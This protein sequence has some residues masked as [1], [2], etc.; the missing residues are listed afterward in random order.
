M[1]LG[2]ISPPAPG[3][4]AG[5]GGISE[6]RIPGVH[7]GAYLR[8]PTDAATALRGRDLSAVR[9]AYLLQR[10]TGDDPFQR[11]LAHGPYSASYVPDAGD[12]EQTIRRVFEL[13][14][15]R[16][17]SATAWVR[18]LPQTPDS[19]LDRL[20][21]YRGP[22]RAE[23]SG[24]FGG[25]PLWRASAALDGDPRTAWIG[26]YD[27]AHP[28][29]IQWRAHRP[30]VI[31]ALSLLPPAEPVR[32]P[33][34]VRIS[35]PG[36]VTGAL[37]VGAGGRVLLPAPVRTDAM[38]I[39]V[40]RAAPRARR[41]G[42]RLACGRDRGA[43]R[44]RWAAADETASGGDV[45]APCGTVAVRV[46]GIEMPLS[47]SGPSSTF[48]QGTPLLARSCRSVSLAAGTIALASAPGPFAV[49]QLELSSPAPR[50][51]AITAGG[52]GQVLNG[53]IDRPGVGRRCARVGH[54]PGVARSRRGLQ[55]RLAS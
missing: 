23:S 19:T 8:L 31:R 45:A 17:F 42:G 11:G 50:P 16:S 43:T 28:A 13:P 46:G 26:D 24:R 48:E 29:W 21:G 49:D 3:V 39:D 1:T 32:R 44:D 40:L 14:V 25:E 6:L 41:L 4:P 47:V 34:E 15:N 5:A 36:A 52:P 18:V 54:R 22:V 35:W 12:A 55:P 38:R 27:P 9:L 53:G 20:A 51:R 30:A 7:A 10:T 33:T 37:P 2:A